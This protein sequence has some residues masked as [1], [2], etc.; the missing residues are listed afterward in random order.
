MGGNDLVEHRTVGL[1]GP[2]LGGR[3]G[4]AVARGVQVDEI[5]LVTG[6]LECLHR[7]GGQHPVEAGRL[8][9]GVDHEHSHAFRTVPA[10]HETLP[11]HP[12]LDVTIHRSPHD[13][14]DFVY[15]NSK[16]RVLTGVVAGLALIAASCSDDD[17]GDSTPTTE[18]PAT[19]AAPEPEAPAAPEPLAPTFL[20][21]GVGE[22]GGSGCGAPHGAYADPGEP[23]GEVRVAWNDPLLSFNNNTSRN[24]AV[25]NANPLYLMNAGFSYYDSA[26]ELVNN[27]T[28]GVCIIESLDPLTITFRINE[29]VTWSDGVQIDAA[30]LILSWGALSTVFNTGEAEFDEEGNY[31]QSDEVIFDAASESLKLV[32]Q[33]PVISDDGLAVTLTW[34]KFYVD[35]QIG[36]VGTTVPAHVVAKNALGIADPAEAKAALIAAFQNKDNA[37]LKPIADFFNSGFDA[38][39]L[40]D[41]PDLYLGSGAYN[42]VSYDEVTQMVFEANPNYTWGPRPQVKT[43][44]Y[45]IIGDPTATVQALANEEIDIMQPQATADVL[46]QLAGLTDRGVEVIQGIGAVY[47]HVDLVVA[48]GGPFDPATY[49]GDAEIARKVRQAFLLTIPR[50][51]IVDRLIK[52]LNPTAEVRNSFTQLPG[53]PPYADM[54]ANNGSSEYAAVDLDRARTL[55]EEAG[56]T[57]PIDVRLLFAANNPRRANEYDLIR[58]SAEQVGFNVIDRSSATWGRELGDIAT[59]DAS[60]F[61]WASTAVDISGSQAN[62]VTGGQNNFGGYSNAT[63]DALYDELQSETDP[64]R[65]SELLIEIE[66]QLW[67][68]AFGVTIFQF[69]AVSAYNSN[70][71]SGVKDL[72]LTPYFFHNF[73]EW[74]AAS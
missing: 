8:R 25:A 22:V 60:L 2:P 59:Y 52:P 73:W 38:N 63:V 69:P 57:T 65:Q 11:V 26:L 6:L 14:E 35:Y 28:Y 58:A 44:V 33:F 50:Q 4:G 18:A 55:L 45:R 37:A 23:S 48:N 62:F 27:D 64:A 67:A 34:D 74:T 10:R 40:P 7:S 41:D 70:Y 1:V 54:V 71:V 12:D 47:E 68:D 49:G 15:R 9:V 61:G 66:Q 24:N 5:D 56:V 72:S 31:V 29:G 42:L 51:D 43:I 21:A 39:K 19:T 13:E 3:H 46:D 32:T 36:G 53:S 20:S 17:G 30:D 16:A